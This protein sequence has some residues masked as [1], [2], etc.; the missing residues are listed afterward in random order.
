MKSDE[1]LLV[2]LYNRLSFYFCSANHEKIEVNKKMTLEELQKLLDEF[3]EKHKGD[4]NEV[5]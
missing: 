4:N 1:I 3:Y 2:S 5:H